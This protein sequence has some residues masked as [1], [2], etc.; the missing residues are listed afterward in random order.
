MRLQLHSGF[1]F[2]AHARPVSYSYISGYP[3]DIPS[4]RMFD[5]H[6]PGNVF[7][8][9][10]RSVVQDLVRSRLRLRKA[11]FC[12]TSV[13]SMHRKAPDECEIVAHY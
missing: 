9:M 10:I 13:F 1:L 12:S 5:L 6:C 11:A 3:R 4:I 7:V 8:G 2:D